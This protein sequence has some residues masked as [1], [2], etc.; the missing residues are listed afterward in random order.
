MARRL[1]NLDLPRY[2]GCLTRLR[3]SNKCHCCDI[4]KFI[5]LVDTVILEDFKKAVTPS[6]YY[7]MAQLYKVPCKQQLCIKCLFYKIVE[8]KPGCFI[9]MTKTMIQNAKQ[10]RIF[11]NVDVF[12]FV[13]EPFETF[14][15]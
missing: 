10:A 12:N 11:K 8:E 7:V 13:T 14:D 1:P 6:L 2:E 3:Y 15:K 5:P 4:C 9:R